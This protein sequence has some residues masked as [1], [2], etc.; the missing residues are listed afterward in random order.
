M[1]HDHSSIKKEHL[2][3]AI[4]AHEN[5][6]KKSK[7]HKKLFSL[8]GALSTYRD[9]ESVVDDANGDLDIPTWKGENKWLKT[10]SDLVNLAVTA[11]E[12]LADPLDPMSWISG[13]FDVF[14]VIGDI[15]DDLGGDDDV[16]EAE[17]EIQNELNSKEME[18]MQN[19][20]NEAIENYHFEA[21]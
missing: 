9:I 10:G 11:G 3:K 13:A 14:D 17:Q 7:F 20:Q 1:D 19:K 21:S 18:Q 15:F 16:E 2:K 8:G 5:S 6:K 12:I 4:K